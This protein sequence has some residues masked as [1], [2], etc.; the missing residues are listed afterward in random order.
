[1]AEKNFVRSMFDNI[2]PTYDKLNHILSLN[3]DKI[4]RRKAVKRIVKNLKTSESEN[5]KN[6]SQIL[7]FSDSRKLSGFRRGLRYCR[8]NDSFGKSRNPFSD[9]HRHI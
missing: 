7:R 2:A 5:L 6:T 8:F 3:I 1:M 9:R 4:W